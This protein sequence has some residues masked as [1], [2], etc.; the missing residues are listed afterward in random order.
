MPFGLKRAPSTFQRLM[1]HVL[2]GLNGYK[3]FVYLDDVVIYG[4]DL[5]N[6]NEK[7]IEILKCFRKFNLKLQPKKCNFLRQEVKYLRHLLTNKG[8]KP[9]PKLVE[10]IYKY[11]SPTNKSSLE[12]F[13]GLTGYYRS[14]IEK[15]A[16]IAEPLIALKRGK[17]KNFLWNAFADEAFNILKN[18][19]MKPPILIYPDFSKPTDASN[20]AIIRSCFIPGY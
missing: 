1:N 10:A 20:V 11:P 2:S 9:D 17:P 4:Y 15:Y 18:Y 14:F 7:L 19:L 5:V 12:A 8:I 6:H 13:I 16:K 3:C